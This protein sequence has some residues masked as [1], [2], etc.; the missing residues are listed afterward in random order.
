M[1]THLHH[2]SKVSI[3]FFFYYSIISNLNEILRKCKLYS[4][5]IISIECCL[6]KLQPS[7]MLNYTLNSQLNFESIEILFSY[8]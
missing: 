3:H 6:L 8:N 5:I 2:S 4:F 1:S 7:I